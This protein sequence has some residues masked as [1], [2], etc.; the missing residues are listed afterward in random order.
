VVF[1]TTALVL[2]DIAPGVSVPRGLEQLTAAFRRSA[3]P[4]VHAIR[5]DVAAGLLAAGAPNL[6]AELLRA[7]GV[8]TLGWS[9]MALGL[10][11]AGAFDATP[12]DS[13]LRSLGV[14]DVVVGGVVPSAAVT[15]TIRAAEVRGYRTMLA[16]EEL[17]VVLGKQLTSAGSA[18]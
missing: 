8:Q 4:V 17:A 16:T 9:E 13:L 14:R 15:A 12:L 7:G 3:R 2:V 18:A 1:E 6:D 11:S 10:R 5:G